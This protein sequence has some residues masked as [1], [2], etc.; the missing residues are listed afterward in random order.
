MKRKAA[1][2]V[3]ACGLTAASLAL[4]GSRTAG[5]AV[6]STARDGA[7]RALSATFSLSATVVNWFCERCPETPSPDTSPLIL[8]E[9]GE[10]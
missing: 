2:L 4:A 5:D 9:E 7:Q 3:A 6:Y 1:L 10:A 8:P